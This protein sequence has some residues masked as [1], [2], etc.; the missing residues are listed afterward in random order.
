[1]TASS[2]ES[3]F[4]QYANLVNILYLNLWFSPTYISHQ[5]PVFGERERKREEKRDMW[6]YDISH[7]HIDK[8]DVLLTTLFTLALNR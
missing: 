7:S 5:S 1:M 4:Y 3:Y 8:Q 6:K 2:K